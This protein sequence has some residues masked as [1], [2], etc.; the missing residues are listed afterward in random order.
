[1]E[2]SMP[3]MPNPAFADDEEARA[4][5]LIWRIGHITADPSNPSNACLPLYQDAARRAFETAAEH[6]EQPE[7]P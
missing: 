2:E 5:G 4:E 1:M 7:M 3:S 6:S